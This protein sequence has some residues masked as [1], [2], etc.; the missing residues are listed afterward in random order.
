LATLRYTHTH[1][2]VRWSLLLLA[3]LMPFLLVPPAV[4]TPWANDNGVIPY[5]SRSLLQTAIPANAPVSP[6]NA[7]FVQW[8][9]AHEPADYWFIR[10]AARR[11]G[12]GF[13][14]YGMPFAQGS[15]TDPVFKLPSTA[16]VPRGQEFLKTLGF[17][18]P[19]AVFTHAVDNRD[20]PVVVQ[21]RCGNAA[22]PGGFTVWMGNVRDDETRVLKTS[23]GTG[24]NLTGGSFD[25]R[26]NGLDDQVQGSNAPDGNSTR[27]RGIIPDSLVIRDE[28]LRQGMAGARGGTLG[29]VLVV[30]FLETNTAA[31]FQKPM[32]G[33]QSG[34][35][36]CGG[37][38][39]PTICA[40]GQRIRINPNIDLAA[41]PGCTGAAR[42]IARTLQVY[43][44]YIGD[45]S[46]SGSGIKAEQNTT[47]VPSHEALKPCMHL[48]DLQI[49]TKGYSP[50]HA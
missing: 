26:Y 36:G 37:A 48:S 39:H 40:E 46:G 33:D 4:A 23:P 24:G 5:G 35:A 19:R 2:L 11:G 49:I 17:H 42:V 13:D 15:C 44:A 34:N 31:G 9:K 21:D 25:W 6:D 22:R 30:Y 20:N 12:D 45:N 14:N 38:A 16:T 7:Y 28:L 18:A 8:V 29:H 32:T 1:F 27:S 41:K 43:G 3:A 50:P 47:V 10:G